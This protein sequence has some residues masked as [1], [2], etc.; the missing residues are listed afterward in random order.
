M[1]P[2]RQRRP[3]RR[4]RL[5]RHRASRSSRV[6]LLALGGGLSQGIGVLAGYVTGTEARVL[7]LTVLIGATFLLALP[8]ALQDVKKIWY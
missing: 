7:A 8:S 3:Q 1:F 6:A 2:A 4:C 5:Y